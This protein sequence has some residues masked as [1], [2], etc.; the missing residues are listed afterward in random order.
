MDDPF[1][2]QQLIARLEAQLT[3]AGRRAVR[4]CDAACRS[5]GVRLFLVCGTLRDLML[6]RESLDVDLA[7]EGDALPIARRVA[8]ETGARLVAHQRF[9]TAK[10]STRDF[11]IDLAST[12]RETYA[13]PGALPS[14]EPATLSEDLAR[15]DFSINAFALQL[16]P[17]AGEL[18][19]P[20]RGVADLING[21]V[22]VLHER[23]FQDDATRILRGVRYAARFGFKLQRETE[24]LLRHDLGYLRTISGPRLRREMALLFEEGEAA[25]GTLL[26]QRN[27]VLAAIHPALRLRGDVAERWAEARRGPRIA[28]W[29][30]LGFCLVADPRDEGAA[31][32][33][34]RWLH[35][36]GRIERALN[37]L[38]RLR[39]LSDKLA[40]T[41]DSPPAAVELLDGTTPSAVWALSLLET[42]AAGVACREYLSRWRHRK[43][44][45]S[46]DD[47]LALGVEPGV[48]VGEMLRQ[49]RRAKLQVEDMTRDQEIELVKASLP[50][51]AH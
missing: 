34:T 27:G 20:F 15:R 49:L 25:A 40:R 50:R 19:D 39:S 51:R 28:P 33:V 13:H 26:A 37:D 8:N 1:G 35:L 44:S 29:D 36:T 30:E 3:P 24:A 42:G 23:S 10:L 14:V 45:L 9:G 11:R 41:A 17:Q 16:T 2:G 12:R 47:L 38:V 6:D 22:R 5:A 31:A 21:L 7:V 48:A 4:A 32:S 46:G 18:V 43:P